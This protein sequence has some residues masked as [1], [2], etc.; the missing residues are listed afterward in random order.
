MSR[1][2][3]CQVLVYCDWS[4]YCA[5]EPG[6]NPQVYVLSSYGFDYCLPPPD[7][8]V[9]CSRIVWSL[10]HSNTQTYC[11]PDPP[12]DPGNPGEPG[13]PG[14]PGSPD[15][16]P[17]PPKT[18]C[19][20]VQPA[21]TARAFQSALATLKYRAVNPPLDANGKPLETG[22]TF[23]NPADNSTYVTT[24][25]NETTIQMGVAVG[26]TLGGALHTH[27]P[28]EGTLPLFSPADLQAIYLVLTDPDNLIDTETFTYTIVIHNGESYTL[29]I[30]DPSAFRA[31]GVRWLT[32]QTGR[33]DLSRAFYDEKAGGIGSTS[34]GIGGNEKA[35]LSMLK[36]ED[37][38][39][40][41][42]K[43]DSNTTTWNQLSLNQTNTSVSSIPCL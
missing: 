27:P 35:F 10:N 21:A 29:T 22:V 24:T 37:S 38:G 17:Q 32:D 19:Q 42:L 12:Y 6:S 28:G 30:T 20:T 25:G 34:I 43:L 14:D 5:V 11:Q 39:L 2:T 33:Q 3:S 15:P 41:L 23:L 1:G 18:P 4:G 26:G 8:N 7:D 36:R 13:E 40:A 31:F 9:G 16:T